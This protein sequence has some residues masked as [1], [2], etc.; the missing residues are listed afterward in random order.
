MRPGDGREVA[1]RVFRVQPRLDGV[2]DLGRRLAR[3][4]A[5]RGHLQLGLDQVDPG[6][7][8]G[9]RVLHLQP[10]VH[11]EEREPLLARLVE[12]LDGAR[13]LVADGQRQPLGRRLELV[14]LRRGQHRR[15]GLLDHLLV[16]PLHRAVPYAQRPRGALAVRD[17]LDLDVPGPG[18]QPLQEH[19]TAA[20]RALGLHP[21][22]LVGL[23]ELLRGR[24]HPDAPAAAARGG[25]EHQRVADLVRHPDRGVQVADRA[26]APRRDRDAD[27]LGDQLGADLVAELAHRLRG[28]AHERHPEPRAQF[29]ER[30]VLG[31]ESPADPGRVR[32]AVPQRPLQHGQ[33]QVGPGRRRAE[34]A[35]QVSGPDEG[36]RAVGVGVERHGLDPRPGLGG[37]FAD[38]VDEP[39]RGLPTVDDG[40]TTE[41]RPGLPGQTH[42]MSGY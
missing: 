14:R 17:H 31:D 35:A 26:A 34:V 33:V 40:D 8:L 2:P 3:Q 22:A 18:E 30:R 10:G 7:Q 36:G 37:E 6:G 41:H 23:G 39:H 28:R 24:D 21:G 32:A 1:V 13:A 25:L 38:G 4:L 9:D 42:V 11:L 20:E 27:L 16:A 5:A 19:H 15:R 29:G 12:E